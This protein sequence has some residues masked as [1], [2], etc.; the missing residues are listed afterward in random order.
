MSDRVLTVDFETHPIGTEEPG[1]APVPVGMSLKLG[2]RKSRYWAWGHDAGGNNCTHAEAISALRRGG[3]S[4]DVIVA[5]NAPFEIAVARDH[6]HCDLLSRRVVDT[7][8]LA[9]LHD[10]YEPQLGLKPLSEKYLNWPADEGDE[11]RDWL[12]EHKLITRARK[13]FGEF[14]WR[15][16][17]EVVRRYAEGDTDRA[18]A[19]Y[20]LWRE[21]SFSEGAER[22][23]R[24]MPVLLR[25]TQ[26]GV[27]MDKPGVRRH[28]AKYEDHLAANQARLRELLR[29]PELDFSK[30]EQLGAAI[31]AQFPDVQM[32]LTPTGRIST[33]RELLQAVL[34]DG[35]TKARLMYD[36][37]LSQT[38]KMFLR[39]WA[40]RLSAPGVTTMHPTWNATPNDRDL[41]AH[42]GR[43]SS[44][45]NWQNLNDHEK[46][47]KLLRDLNAMA[48]GKGWELPALR[49]YVQAPSGYIIV[50]RDY[51]QIELRDAAHHAGDAPPHVPLTMHEMFRDRP[52]T[53]LHEYMASEVRERFARDI[54]RRAAKVTGFGIIYGT[55]APGLGERM[56][57]SKD[58]A[59]ELI[60]AYLSLLPD[61][62]WLM[63]EV[64]RVGE[65]GG[66]VTTV[67]G[68]R[69]RSAPPVW[70]DED[71]SNGYWRRLDYKLLN[72]LIQGGCADLMKEAM[73]EIDR[74]GIPLI[75]SVHDEPVALSP[76]N[77]KQCDEI[78]AEM[79]E[80]MVE[81]EV[82]RRFTVPI[83][84]DA[85]YGKRWATKK[86]I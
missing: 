2:S 13:T 29:A 76:R 75:M 71:D 53:D 19:L 39:P 9:F 50:G 80:A 35:E 4:S 55:G 20:Q 48:P 45:P 15:A 5:H 79:H 41:G 57:I 65:S 86:E 34:P 3:L 59:R 68:R 49:D 82:A 47:E 85:Y 16:P 44:T 70:V 77:K 72:Y 61:L 10:P 60:N 64:K 69:Y 21:I 62:A 42:T 23:W 7:M 25:M 56:G 74:R 43:L 73:I 54:D 46:E 31:E 58:D 22:E 84:T 38:L 26:R 24:L 14:I 40:A 8:V 66:Y 67:G 28:L 17:G 83:F 33:K 37:S 18:Y 63:Q 12:R 1:K 78:L 51:S 30:R 36:S 11:I 32:P 52:D 6:M 27:P 81:N